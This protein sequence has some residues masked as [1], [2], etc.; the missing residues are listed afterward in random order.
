MEAV[1][2]WFPIAISALLS[3]VCHP[4]LRA[5]AAAD[6]LQARL[7]GLDGVIAA[8]TQQITDSKGYIVEEA[9]GML[10]LAKPRFRWEV[11]APFAQIILADGNQVQIYDPDLE[12]VTERNIDGAIDQAPLALLTRSELTLED[13]FMVDE[14][15]IDGAYSRY[16]LRP[17]SSDALFERLELVFKQ[18]QLDTLAIY[19]H[20]GQ[21][22]LI[23]FTDY[24]H[25]Q[26]IQS[27]MFELDYP[28]GTDFVRG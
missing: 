24:A 20:A 27:S 11:K 3:V 13:H 10:H 16:V 9:T 1:K 4:A 14:P 25:T 15:A 12:Q 21:Q 19:D 26:V 17:I 2:F 7:V 18:Q 28:P 23:R 5:D 22:T 6:E 8:F